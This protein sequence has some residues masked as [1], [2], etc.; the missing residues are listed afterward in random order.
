MVRSQQS[1][2]TPANITPLWRLQYDGRAGAPM[3]YARLRH[4]RVVEPFGGSSR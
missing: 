2:V 3:A 4:G 1:V